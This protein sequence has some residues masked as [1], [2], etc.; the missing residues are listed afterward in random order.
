MKQVLFLFTLC[1][2]LACTKSDKVD[3]VDN[4]PDNRES[5]I[6]LHT[7]FGDMYLWLH[8]ETP[9]H[10]ENFLKL[11]GE[12]YYNGTT[13]HRIINNFMIQGGDPNSLDSDTTNDGKGGPGYTIEAEILDTF[14][15]VRGALAAA[16]LPNNVNPTKASSGSQFYIVHKTNGSTASLNGQ[17]TVFGQVIKGVEIV[18]QIIVQPKN[19][20]D[21][22]L[23]NIPMTVSVIKKTKQELLDEFG[24]SVE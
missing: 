22:P 13:F 18:D 15:H 24:L 7:D 8:K 14:V 20:A 3:P 1:G 10:R 6:K 23:T 4:Q 17:Y 21:R 2:I 11:A 9:L 19:S 16:R 12:G 5:I